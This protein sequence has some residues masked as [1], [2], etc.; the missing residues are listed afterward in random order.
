MTPRSVVNR[1]LIVFTSLVCLFSAFIFIQHLQVR[2]NPLSMNNQMN[3]HAF[4][5]LLKVLL[6]L[7]VFT[8]VHAIWVRHFKLSMFMISAQTL[9]I[10]LCIVGYRTIPIATIPNRVHFEFPT[11]GITPVKVCRDNA[12]QTLMASKL[13]ADLVHAPQALTTR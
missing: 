10:V 6:P 2:Q 12:K 13:T 8:I 9:S 7:L 4:R 5:M 1:V 3:E 11:T